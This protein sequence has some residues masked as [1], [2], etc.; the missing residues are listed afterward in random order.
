MAFQAKDGSR[1]H[2]ASRAKLHDDMAADTAAKPMGKAKPDGGAA[3]ADGGEGGGQDLSHMP[4]HEVVA[5]HGPAHKVEME[6]DHE[7]GSHKK[8]SHHG[9]HKHVSEHENAHEA[10][11]AGMMS[12]GAETPD[13]EEET[14]DDANRNLSGENEEEEE[15]AAVPGM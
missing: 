1:H 3:G 2:S 6:H 15:S 13:A 14:P 4:I 11:Q 5:K 7:G 8:T 12:A 10:H 9:K